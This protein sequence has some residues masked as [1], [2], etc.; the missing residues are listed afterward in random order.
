MERTVLPY[1]VHPDIS[2][3][4]LLIETPDTVTHHLLL[5]IK[6]FLK[7]KSLAHSNSFFIAIFIVLSI[8]WKFLVP[9]VNFS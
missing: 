6:L 1:T 8:P 2:D 3:W 4:F 9:F 7:E 5:N